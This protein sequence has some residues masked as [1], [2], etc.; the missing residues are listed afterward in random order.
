[1]FRKFVPLLGAGLVITALL[2]FFLRPVSL[3][4]DGQT[5]P[6][7]GGLTVGHTLLKAGLQP[8]P[9]DQIEPSLSSLVPLN[10]IITV[11]HAARVTLWE[12]GRTRRVVALAATPGELLDNAGVALA[13]SD[14]LYWNGVPVSPNAPLPQDEEAGVLQIQRA[15]AVI[16]DH[17]GKRLQA[18]SAVNTV[19]GALWDA[20]VQIRPGD[21]L[22]VSAG[23]SLDSLDQYG[24]AIIALRTAQPVTIHTAGQQVRVKSTADT[25]GQALAEAGVALQALD[26]A[27]PAED[28]P[29][30][31]DGQVRVIRVREEVALTQE[32]LP[33][34]SQTVPDP[35]GEMDQRRVVEPG[36]YG[37]KVV[38][39]R[40]RFEDK[41]EVARAVDSDW[42]AQEPVPQT[43]GIGTQVV[44][45]TLDVP[46]GQIEYWRAV[47]VYATSYSPCRLGT[48]DGSCGYVTASGARLTKGI[49][50]VTRAWYRIIAGMQVYV[51]RYGYGVIGD[52]GG[53]I[54]GQ[55]WIDLGFEDHDFEGIVGWTTMYFLTPV[56][57][58]TAWSLP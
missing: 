41:R 20:K 28:Q 26:Y 45:K 6:I 35:E 19:S 22:S 51:P 18:D 1:M 14:R 36:K 53:G 44:V 33:F 10:G 24:P 15:H 21:K 25:V 23:T 32:A 54:P 30:P 43:V 47:N 11:N 48:E 4:V 57:A 56:P 31:E 37:V 12:D 49:I 52:V 55:P 8:H 39:E 58:N 7:S 42:T 9:E 17:N 50:A 34:E 29:L 16:I 3:I 13:P 40:M 5:I 38:R 27:V 2:G 46:G